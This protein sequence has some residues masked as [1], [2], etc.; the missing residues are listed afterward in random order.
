MTDTS[1]RIDTY[2][3]G[4]AG[5]VAGEL[6]RLLSAHDGLHLK[7][8]VSES[9][10]GKPIEAVFPHLQSSFEGRTF[11][12][13]AELRDTLAAAKGP[14]AIFS[15]AAHGASA[16]LVSDVLEQTRSATDVHVVDLSADF[17]YADADA[18]EAVYGQPHGAVELLPAFSCALPEHVDETPQ[19]IGNPGCFA[20]ALMLTTVPLL[21]LGIAQP[22]LF[23]VGITGSTGSGRA[24][25]ETTHHPLR[26]SNL[27]AYKPLSHRHAPEVVAITERVTGIKPE[28]HFIPHSGPFAR[29]IHMTV[30]GKL[31]SAMDRDAVAAEL[32]AFYAS[33]PF[34]RV[35]DG[36]PK[37]KD[38][39]GSNYA[40]MG[41][42]VEGDTIAVFSVIDNLTKGAAG[43]GLQWMNRLHGLPE[44]MGL[45]LSGPGWI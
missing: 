1:E 7:A 39:V 45:S 31:T 18:Y 35:V 23:A 15:A 20:T 40:H 32:E 44:T 8:A 3:L 24:P 33:S 2:V 41:V 43:G 4:A 25:K 17:R 36:T 42:A 28:L 19:H 27:F 29:G 12:T 26:Q 13:P 21:K 38:V 14:L 5:Y 37:V 10:A 30:Q 9:Q 22:E 16:A 6:F 11:A 34:V